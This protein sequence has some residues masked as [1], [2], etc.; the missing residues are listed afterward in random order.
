[1]SALP[2]RVDL[3]DKVAVVTG[4]SGVLGAAM[5]RALATCGAK[6][7]ILGRDREK[8]ESLAAQLERDGGIARGV[9]CNVV[10]RGS[11][12]AAAA[13]IRGALGPCD[14]LINGAGGNHPKATAGQEYFDP[15]QAA[16][17][18]PAE[19]SFFD[20]DVAGFEFVF[21]LNLL[22]TVLPCQVFGRQML[23][24]TGCSIINISSMSALRPLTKVAAYSAAKAAV[25]NLTQ[26]LATHFAHSGI[27]VNAIAP[28]FFITEQNRR[29]MIKDDGSHTA[30]AQKVIAQT[31]MRRFG[32]PEELLG[33]MMWLADAKSS[34][35]VT[36]TIIAIDGGFSAYA[37]V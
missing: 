2:F 21:N 35:F 7:A 28:G 11:L 3:K 27:R 29:L 32:Q 31:P 18:A 16:S 22:G 25:N 34:G 24:R 6:V 13:E 5:C 20:L 33:A 36:G 30:R 9:S 1:M 23:G 19:T 12:E 8:A 15:N 10:D 17:G 4:G 26:W 14:L 37:G